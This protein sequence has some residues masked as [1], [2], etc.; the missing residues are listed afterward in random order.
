[1]EGDERKKRSFWTSLPGILTAIAG[2]IT[3]TAAIVSAIAT[4][5]GDENRSEPT[6]PTASSSSEAPAP[7][8]TP[9][10]TPAQTHSQE[11]QEP[12][13]AAIDV[14]YR[15]DPYGCSLFLQVEIAGVTASPQGLRHTIRDLPVGQQDYRV[16]GTITCP[17]IG[18][19]EAT[20]EG[21]VMVLEGREYALIWSNTDIGEC[22]VSLQ[23]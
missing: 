10:P 23:Q 19:C 17:T 1:V 3:G 6:A 13:T 2:I 15:G 4:V 22:S 18:D 11:P 9:A 7:T 20:G 5:G 8:T 14:V 16:S 12:Q 21:K